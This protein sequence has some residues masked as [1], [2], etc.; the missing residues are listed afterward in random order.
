MKNGAQVVSFPLILTVDRGLPVVNCTK[1]S[2][3]PNIVFWFEGGTRANL[4]GRDYVLR[5]GRNRCF[6]GIHAGFG[7]ASGE[8]VLGGTF[9]RK[10]YTEF[11]SK[12]A[13]IG[14]ARGATGT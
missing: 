8:W 2:G 13:R 11:D 1:V 6:L 9:M 3:L 10:F 12:N 4:S 14:I 7:L 5:M